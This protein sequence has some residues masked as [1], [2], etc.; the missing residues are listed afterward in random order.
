MYVLKH[1]RKRFCQVSTHISAIGQLE[2]KLEHS[3]LQSV[4]DLLS[5]SCQS[6]KTCESNFNKSD[7]VLKPSSTGLSSVM[8]CR[9]A[10]VKH[11]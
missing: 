10:Y 11:W 3:E 5:D 6:K 7:L 4:F 9:I 8:Q 1:A 2:V